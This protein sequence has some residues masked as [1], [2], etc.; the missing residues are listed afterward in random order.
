MCAFTAGPLFRVFHCT[1]YCTGHYTRYC[2]RYCT[3]HCVGIELGIAP[4]FLQALDWVLHYLSLVEVCI[5]GSF[6]VFDCTGCYTIYC[7]GYCIGCCTRYC[8][9]YC[10]GYLA[11]YCTGYSMGY[12]IAWA[13]WKCAFTAASE[14]SST[15][16]KSPINCTAVWDGSAAH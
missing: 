12:C 1:T 11:G 8:T 15:G 9:G 6:R 2:T 13:W 5:Y 3:L 16:W 4:G 7:T 14:S 10:T